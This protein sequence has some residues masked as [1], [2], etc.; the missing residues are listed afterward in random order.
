MKKRLQKIYALAVP[1]L[2]WNLGKMGPGKKRREKC[3]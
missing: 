3:D 2:R 1:V